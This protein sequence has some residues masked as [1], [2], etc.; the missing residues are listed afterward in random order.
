MLCFRSGNGL[1]ELRTSSATRGGVHALFFK[2][3]SFEPWRTTRLA[4]GTL[5]T[6]L[7]PKSVA[8]DATSRA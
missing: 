7:P 3:P 6:T 5:E 2:R 1:A 8:I 4:K